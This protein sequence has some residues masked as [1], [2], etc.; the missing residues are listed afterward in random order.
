MHGFMRLAARAILLAALL[1]PAAACYDA[2]HEIFG[3]KDAVLVPGLEGSYITT[4]A[5][6]HSRRYFVTRAARG[7]EYRIAVDLPGGGLGTLRAIPLRYNL[8]LA[9]VHYT[10]KPDLYAL[11]LFRV[12]RAGGV[13]A[14]IE[15]L[16][17]DENAAAALAERDHVDMWKQ[18][19]GAEGLSGAHG[20]LVRFL[21]DLAT[22]P[23][24]A[25]P[26][27]FRVTGGEQ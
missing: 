22:I 10:A 23:S 8:Y 16:L 24:K 3:R 13:V 27:Y 5:Q 9:Q 21:R 14:E 6:G 19:K 2:Q 12:M 26:A 11:L 1:L 4:D 25:G 20:S 15:E 17:P 18:D 7:A